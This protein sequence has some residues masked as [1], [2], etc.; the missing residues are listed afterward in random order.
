M[1]Y[2]LEM[3]VSAHINDIGNLKDDDIKAETDKYCDRYLVEN[4]SDISALDDKFNFMMNIIKDTVS[5]LA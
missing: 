5:E 2:L 4:C 3:F 1:H